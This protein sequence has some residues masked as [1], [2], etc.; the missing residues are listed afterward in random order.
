MQS[1]NYR[2]SPITTKTQFEAA[3]A[4][5]VD[6]AKQLSEQLTGQ[7]LNLSN[8]KIFAHYPD[9]FDFLKSVVTDYGKTS[10][11]GRA[12]SKYVDCSHQIGDS[13]LTKIG[14]RVAD[15]YRSHVGCGDY[16]VKDPQTFQRF[17]PQAPSFVRHFPAMPKQFL[18]LWHPDFDVLAYIPL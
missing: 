8:A 13:H 1:Y 12:T 18:E 2:F 9:E 11:A 15:P 14:V 5:V 3:L 6:Q 16:E 10:D 7:K 17:A 4:Y